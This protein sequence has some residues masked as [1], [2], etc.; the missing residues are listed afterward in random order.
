MT[1]SSRQTPCEQERVKLLREIGPLPLR[2][3]A[4]PNWV[5]ALAWVVLVVIAIQ[6]VRTAA[7]PI[8]H[9]INPL[10]AGGILI[11]FFGLVVVAR[12]MLTSETRITRVGIEQSWITRRK[13]SW[14]EIQ[15]AKFTPLLAS[16]RLICFV[17]AGRP[18]VFQAGTRELQAA[19][20]RI[21][22]IY[23]QKQ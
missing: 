15:F 11:C 18:V 5:K 2:G 9:T 16:K 8:G 1:L 13:V 3:M 23:Q 21:A 22:L 10:L 7:S 12:F 20:A 19:F 14:E 17:G 4:W 6:I